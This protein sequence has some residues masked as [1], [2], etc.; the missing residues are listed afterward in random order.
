MACFSVPMELVVWL[1]LVSSLVWVAAVAQRAMYGV[2][3]VLEDVDGSGLACRFLWQRLRR[4]LFLQLF[5]SVSS[6]SS[7]VGFQL[8]SCEEVA[9]WSL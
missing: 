5:S 8:C 1:G 7:G 6:R 4:V 2:L 3:D 9:C